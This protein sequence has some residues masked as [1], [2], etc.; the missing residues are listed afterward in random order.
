MWFLCGF[1]VEG[2]VL[3]VEFVLL[4]V[5]LFGKKGAVGPRANILYVFCI[6]IAIVGFMADLLFSGPVFFL[7]TKD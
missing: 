1:F 7:P 2:S 3:V 6:L 4:E 5:G